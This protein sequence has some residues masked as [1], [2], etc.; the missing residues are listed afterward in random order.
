M[1]NFTYTSHSTSPPQCTR[2]ASVTSG[3]S[4][5]KA[6]RTRRRGDFPPEKSITHEPADF[7]VH[8]VFVTTE[9]RRLH[10]KTPRL[11][12]TPRPPPPQSTFRQ[13]RTRIASY[14]G[15]DFSLS[16]A[17]SVEHFSATAR[18]WPKLTS[19]LDRSELG[20]TIHGCATDSC[21]IR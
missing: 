19:D 7:H 2:G 10:G 6:T 18:K 8:V 5:W 4:P 12:A 14:R 3:R 16:H 15:S 1:T 13:F 17:A 11:P 20:Q 9:P 21:E